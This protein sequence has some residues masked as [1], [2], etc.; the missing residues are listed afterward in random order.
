M[1]GGE[2]CLFSFVGP[3][4]RKNSAW[5]LTHCLVPRASPVPDLD[6]D[7]SWDFGTHGG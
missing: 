4:M 1:V 2:T 7:E 6:N 5:E 3:Q